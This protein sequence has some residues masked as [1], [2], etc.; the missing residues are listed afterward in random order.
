M[1]GEEL[2][3]GEL[4]RRQSD[5]TARPTDAKRCRVELQ[6]VDRDPRRSV[7]RR[8]PAQCPD[9]RSKLGHGKRLREVVVGAMVEPGYSIRHGVERRQHEDRSIEPALTERRTDGKT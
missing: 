5:L 4:P 3:E 7:V 2:Q 9:P 8:P 6:I 1:A